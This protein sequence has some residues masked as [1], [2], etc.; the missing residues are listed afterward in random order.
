MLVS[1]LPYPLMQT[2]QMLEVVVVVVQRLGETEVSE[3]FT[4]PMGFSPKYLL[5]DLLGNGQA[6]DPLVGAA[7][8]NFDQT[9][10]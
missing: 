2:E 9:T 8:A 5:L 10:E 7:I 4:H 1:H 3:I 6:R